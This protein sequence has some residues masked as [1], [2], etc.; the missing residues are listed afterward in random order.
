MASRLRDGPPVVFLGP[1]LEASEAARVLEAVYLPPA[2]QG[3]I[4]EAVERFRPSAIGLIDGSFQ[5]EPAVRHKEILW[6]LSRGIPVIGAASMGALRAAELWPYGVRG[7]GVIFRW[8]RRIRFAPDD[9]VAVLQGPPE[10][11]SP[12]LT[13][14][15]VDLRLTFRLA[16]RRGRIDPAL[17]QRL[18]VAA[19]RLNFR[20]R[21]LAR[22]VDVAIADD[23][24][25]RQRLAAELRAAFVSQKKIDALSALAWMTTASRGVTPQQ[26][27]FRVTAAFLRDLEDAG[28]DARPVGRDAG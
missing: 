17:R 9:A 12:P 23:S 20:D 24:G 18:E 22:V 3:S 26:W 7:I 8:Y 19:G 27:R 4:V 11:G 16:E 15:L 10:L 6:A 13:R 14:A 5:L 1:T 2:T 21:T 25:Q 28:I